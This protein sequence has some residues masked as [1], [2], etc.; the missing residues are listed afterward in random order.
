MAKKEVGEHSKVFVRQSTGLVKNASFLDA[1]SLNISDMSAGAALATIGFTTVLLSSMAGVN[2][3]VASLIAFLLMVPQLVIYTV[4]NRK[5]PRTGGDYV[6]ISRIFGGLFGGSLAFMGYVLET[7]AYLALIA[8]STVFAIGSVGVALGNMSFL[9]LALS[10]NMKG[11]APLLQFIIAAVLFAILI[12]VNIVKPKAG[13]KLVSSLIIFGILMVVVSIAV[14]LF[15]GRAG[16]ESYVTSLQ[17]SGFNETYSQVAA[18]SGSTKLNLSAVLFLLPFFSIFVYPW[19][20]A[21]PAVSSEIRGKKGIRWAIPAAALLVALLVTGSFG[22]MY[23]VGGIKFINGA[24]SN[25]TLV[26]DYSFNFWT[27]A[28]GVTSAYWL[29]FV[30]GI[31]WIAW[32][33]AILAY[34]IIVFSRY[35]FAM[36]F[37][38]F[39][40]EK[41]AYV[42]PRFGSPVNAHLLDLAITVALI[43]LATFI[44][45][46]FSSLYG[47][48]VASMIYFAFIG[49]AA[50]AYGLRY[51][52]ATS[53]GTL[54]LFG[55]LTALVFAYITYQFLAYPAIWGGNA[56][57]YGYVALSFIAGIIVY[58]VDKRRNLKKGINI[59]LAFKEIPPE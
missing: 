33:I 18:S 2:L 37:D 40:P 12:L 46:P 28:M 52:K 26:Y 54:V 15:A 14:L 27:L 53:K 13:Y 59:D 47:A 24:L 9:G 30:I 4:M 8:I 7:L 55:A 10:G 11:S 38:R 50:A 19:I 31:G 29:K 1:I 39:L 57:A 22:A 23:Y 51:E 36:A 21:S 41:L 5:V 6:W 48:V 32:D 56:L 34:G 44:Y 17:A 49:I 3:V 35:L 20:N 16:V 25:P 45:G 43:A 42:S 58:F